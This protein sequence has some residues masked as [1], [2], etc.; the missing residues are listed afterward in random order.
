MFAYVKV[1]R[2]SP[3]RPVGLKLAIGKNLYVKN[4]D[5]KPSTPKTNYV[6]FILT[7]IYAIATGLI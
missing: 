1:A 5:L 7:G 6:F 4:A 2:L 3:Q